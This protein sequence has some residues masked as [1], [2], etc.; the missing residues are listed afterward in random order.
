[1]IVPDGMKF[2]EALARVEEITSLLNSPSTAVD[3]MV[4]LYREASLLLVHCEQ[5]LADARL[6]MEMVEVK[7][8][9]Q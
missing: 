8:D 5:K 3:E 9:G 6:K 1:M 4:D 2:E 7:A